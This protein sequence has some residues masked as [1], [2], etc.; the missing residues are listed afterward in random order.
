MSVDMK[1]MSI[2][3]QATSEEACD[4]IA[5]LGVV[6]IVFHSAQETGFKTF[7]GMHLS[8]SLSDEDV[9]RALHRIAVDGLQR[10]ASVPK[11]QLDS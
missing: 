11:R 7:T 2:I 3:V 6:M 8:N 4:A 1:R 9:Y 10:I 5:G